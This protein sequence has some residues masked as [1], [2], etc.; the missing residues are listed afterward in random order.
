MPVDQQT[1]D[2]ANYMATIQRQQMENQAFMTGET[3]RLSGHQTL[4][5]TVNDAVKRNSE[6]ASNSV[7]TNSESL[8]AVC[9]NIK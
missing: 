2:N 8:N 1:M 5:Q 6:A 9:R 7:K 3:S 4:T